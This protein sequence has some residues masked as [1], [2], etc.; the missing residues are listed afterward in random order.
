MTKFSQVGLVYHLGIDQE[1]VN[2]GFYI[3]YSKM[4]GGVF[5]A[6]ATTCF[7]AVN[8][9]IANF[10]IRNAPRKHH[11]RTTKYP[12]TEGAHKWTSSPDM[13]K[14]IQVSTVPKAQ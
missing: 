5:L 7:T 8:K 3:P 9:Y 11:I 4:G 14:G 13:F 1:G 6:F 2:M 10:F 12:D